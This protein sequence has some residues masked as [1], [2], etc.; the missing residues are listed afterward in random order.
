MPRVPPR[1]WKRMLAAYD[2]RHFEIHVDN[3]DS[4]R[5]LLAAAKYEAE[6]DAETRPDRIAYLNTRKANLQS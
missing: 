2:D 6:R 5:H 4:K 3:C 1:D